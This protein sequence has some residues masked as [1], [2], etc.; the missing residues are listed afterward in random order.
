MYTVNH[1][2]D[3]NKLMLIVDKNIYKLITLQLLEC[4]LFYSKNCSRFDTE[5]TKPCVNRMSWKW[6]KQGHWM[7]IQTVDYEKSLFVHLTMQI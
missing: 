7:N 6:R 1:I 5:D 4:F 2:N 3:A